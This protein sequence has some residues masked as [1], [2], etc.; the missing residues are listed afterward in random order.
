MNTEAYS[1]FAYQLRILLPSLRGIKAFGTDGELALV[2]AFENAF[3]NALH[4][5]C[6]KH[7]RDNIESKLKSLNLMPSSCEEI[8]CDIFGVTDS[9][10]TQLGLVDAVDTTDFA[11]KLNAL[12]ERWNHFE[13]S[14]KRVVPLEANSTQPEF[15]SYCPKQHDSECKK[16]CLFR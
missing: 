1:Y 5:R 3:P 2:N 10:Q 14:G 7:F 8:L 12:E 13:M 11:S 4:L 15:Y 16:G 6:F 9:E